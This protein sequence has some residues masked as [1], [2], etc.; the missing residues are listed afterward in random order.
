MEVLDAV[1]TWMAAAPNQRE[2][3]IH[4][5]LR[6]VRLHHLSNDELKLCFRMHPTYFRLP[7]FRNMLGNAFRAKA[8]IASGQPYPSDLLPLFPNR[9]RDNNNKIPSL[10]PLDFTPHEK[11]MPYDPIILSHFSPAP[12]KTDRAV[13]I[14]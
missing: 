13:R 9:C 10:Y 4:Q 5:L 14:Q 11:R 12:V 8:L 6:C 1:M 7:F 2:V 3:Y